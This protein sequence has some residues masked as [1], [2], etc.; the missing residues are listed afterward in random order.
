MVF[1]HGT[2]FCEVWI[3]TNQLK[4]WLDID[5]SVID[6]PYKLARDV[7]N[8]GHWGT[9]DTEV[10]LSSQSDLDKVMDIITQAYQQT[11]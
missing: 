2:N 5:L 3:Q 9:G 7:T 10:I 4:L 11:V 1:K 8:K 6:D